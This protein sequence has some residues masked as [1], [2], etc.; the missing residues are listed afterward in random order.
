MLNFR[1]FELL[2][3]SEDLS[4]W[5]LL[6]RYDIMTVWL[7]F[8]ANDK[9]VNMNEFLD[10]FDDTMDFVARMSL[11]DTQ[12]KNLREI[13]KLGKEKIITFS[14]EVDS[15]EKLYKKDEIRLK[16]LLGSYN[17][18]PFH[19]HNIGSRF[20][21]TKYRKDEYMYMIFTRNRTI[22]ES[23][24]RSSKLTKCLLDH[25]HK[26]DASQKELIS[27]LLTPEDYNKVKTIIRSAKYGLS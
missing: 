15:E 7:Y 25:R 4:M 12:A 24:K 3:E 14:G 5:Q 20:P 21:V 17:W 23:R 11:S 27:K 9:N 1:D 10:E 6:S 19:F 8:V 26:F 13:V 2:K 22:E 18:S 16:K